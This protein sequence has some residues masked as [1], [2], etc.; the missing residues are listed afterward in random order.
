MKRALLEEINNNEQEVRKNLDYHQ[1]LRDSLLRFREIFERDSLYEGSPNEAFRY[2][3]G[4]RMGKLPYGAYQAALS[5]GVLT[6]LPIDLLT[7]ISNL[8][9]AQENYD[10]LGINYLDDFT[11]FNSQSSLIDILM[12]MNAF[13]LDAVYAEQEL[14]NYMQ[15]LQNR[16]EGQSREEREGAG[17]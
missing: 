7:D 9:I 2:W 3:R 4:T 17:D 8:Y 13:T 11:N 5:S 1:G 6:E 10:R 16:L 15:L 12:L 14:L